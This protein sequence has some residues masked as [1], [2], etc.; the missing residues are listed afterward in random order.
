MTDN[1]Q[2][3]LSSSS[4][5]QPGFD[6]NALDVVLDQ[7]S[8]SVVVPATDRAELYKGLNRGIVACTESM[9]SL[10]VLKND[11]GQT[12][13]VSQHG[14]RELTP[15]SVAQTKKLLKRVF[16]G[17]ANAGCHPLKGCTAFVGKSFASNGAE[18]VYLLLRK[19]D[20]SS[21]TKQVFNDLA[22][23]LA[24]QLEVFENL[25]SSTRK[26]ESSNEMVGIAQ[27]VQNLGKS[28]SINQLSHN[29]ANDLA[30]IAQADRVSFLTPIGK[31]LAVSG[32]SSVSTRTSLVRSISSIARNASASRGNVEWFGSEVHTDGNRNRKNLNKAVKE[33]SS[34]AGFAIPIKS[35][36]FHVGIAVLEFFDI[37]ASSF[38]ERRELI[39][40]TLKFSTPVLARSISVFSI[41]AIRKLDFFFNR[42]LV[43]PIRSLLSF[44][45]G[46]V[47]LAVCLF[48]LFGV[49]RPFEISAQ[50]TLQPQFQQNV[51]AQLECEVETLNVD[52]GAFVE[53]GQP[54]AVLKSTEVTEELISVSGELAELR[55]QLRNLS[56]SQYIETEE[57]DSEIR[58]GKIAS[59]VERN[60]IR[61]KTL[62]ARQ[63]FLNRRLDL[64]R[65]ASPISGQVTTNDLRRRLLSRPL[66]R[67]D[68]MLTISDVDGPWE[69]ELMIDDLR[70]EYIK[71]MQDRNENPTVKVRFRLAS[72]SRSTFIGELRELDFRASDDQ[73]SSSGSTFVRGFVD[74][75][76]K[77]LGERLRI[78]TRVYGKVDCGERTNFFL[79][80]YEIRN[81]I[82]HWLFY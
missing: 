33:M 74:I 50:G 27:L 47:L 80:T 56:M 37:E 18:F 19:S 31:I 55:Q 25:Q 48:L 14:L 21:L 44:A 30:A 81:K 51:F 40:E 24:D 17:E 3:N 2:Q 63:Q 15:P 11:Q 60:K 69:I 16:S 34:K 39:N 62:E 13:I 64:M 45:F 36:R 46:L 43:R 9:A 75:D 61:V 70:V 65:V 35:N 53:S 78:G 66:D 67:G 41:P 23:E 57:G 68:L 71:A 79:L 52:E 28:T 8:K 72:D 49:S 5:E 26:S 12:R 38:H 20:S 32:V 77:E 73:N 58:R 29:F 42:I 6:L 1:V 4:K 76:E 59:D 54:L 22:A 82:R 7:F 10:I